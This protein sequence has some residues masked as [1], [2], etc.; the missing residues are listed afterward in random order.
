MIVKKVRAIIYDIKD[1]EPYFLIL[2]R[3]LRWSGW[4]IL[5][6]TMEPGEKIEET[7]LRGINEET[8]L[9][10]FEIIKN[11]DKT[12]KWQVDG[13]DYEIIA[14]FLIKAD[15]NEEISLKQEI[16]EHDGYEWANK[17]TVI[18]KLTYLETKEL[19]KQLTI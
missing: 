12:E 9:K 15:M 6:E 16:I 10:N 14:T 2:H 8:G 7:L 19:I 17:E 11:L 18:S 1:N 13:I 5:K 3:I 4:E